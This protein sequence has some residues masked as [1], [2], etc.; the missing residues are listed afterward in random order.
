MGKYVI[1][2]VAAAAF[3]G[4]GC[5]DERSR[6]G[7]AD[8]KARLEKELA[9]LTDEYARAEAANLAMAAELERTRYL[10]D[11]AADALARRDALERELLAL[12]AG[13][14]EGYATVAS[15]ERG[16][17]RAGGAAASGETA[18]APAGGG[19]VAGGRAS[20]RP[21]GRYAGPT[22][23]YV[24]AKGD[25][26]SKIAASALGDAGAWP[27]I[28]DANEVYVRDPD[29]IFAGQRLLIP[30]L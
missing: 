13:A 22:R 27:L 17:V 10:G 20:G 16:Q 14:A 2:L 3:L 8:E 24:V 4:A 1:W 12:R 5:R 23:P 26:L 28:Y 9:A 30:T 7:M 21:R 29:W 19:S 15:G 11:A 25:T 18:G 6:A